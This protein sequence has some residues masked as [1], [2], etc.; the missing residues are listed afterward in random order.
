MVKSESLGAESTNDAGPSKADISRV[1]AVLG[2]KGGKVGGKARFDALTPERRR[3]P[4]ILLPR[5]RR[6]L[7]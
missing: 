6:V 5:H 1:M 3:R 7:R 4:Q 2:R